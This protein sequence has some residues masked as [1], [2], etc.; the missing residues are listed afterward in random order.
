MNQ[1]YVY[2]NGVFAIDAK[3]VNG[4]DIAKIGDTTVSDKFNSYDVSDG[5]LVKTED[6]WQ[7]V[8]LVTTAD[9][10][11]MPKRFACF[12][13]DTVGDG[14]QD[15][16]IVKTPGKIVAMGTEEASGLALADLSKTAGDTE[17]VPTI[18]NIPTAPN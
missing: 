17:P 2:R 5:E 9:G 6:G 4:T 8:F 18:Q 16:A 7:L 1:E 15:G 10:K 11:A 3:F 12:P 14:P 13:S